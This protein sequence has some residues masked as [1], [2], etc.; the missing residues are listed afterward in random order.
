MDPTTFSLTKSAGVREAKVGDLVRYTLTLTNTGKANA[1]NAQVLDTPPAGFSYVAGSMAVADADGAFTLGASQSPLQIGGI[2][3]AAG[4]QATISYLLR[5]GA[6]VRQGLYT[7]QAVAQDASGKP[8]SNI[9]TAQVAVVGDP[10]VD[11]SLILGTVFHD[12]DGDGWQA[13]ATMSGVRVQGGF[14]PGVYQPGSTTVDRGQGPVPEPDASAPLLHGIEVGTVAGRQTVADAASNHQVVIR[15]RVSEPTFTDDFVLTSK[16]GVTLRMNAS[17]QTVVEKAGEAAKGMNGAAP[18]VER[19]I[20]QVDGAYEVAYIIRNEGIDERGIPGVRLATVEGLLIET[21]Q[22]GRFNVTG[23]PGG[24]DHRGRNFIMKVDP[25]TLPSGAEL[26]TANPLVRRITPG[27]PA[28]FD[29][30]V[31]APALVLEG[32]KEQVDVVLGEVLFAPGSTELDP[33]YEPVIQKMAAKVNE[34]AGGDVVI[35]AN[36]EAQALALGRAEA[37]ERAMQ[38]LLT[39]AAAKAVRVTARTEL[40]QPLSTVVG[41]QQG[42]IILGT[43]LFD[44]DLA[45]VK[46]QFRPL[47]VQVVKSLNERGG[48]VV[49]LVGHTDRRASDAYNLALGLRR[50]RAVFEAIAKELNPKVRAKVRVETLNDAQPAVRA[51]AKK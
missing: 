36:G 42:E 14:A 44:T 50:A 49:A 31:K 11:E 45:V 4:K 26:T 32:A 41:V 51:S 28:R 48:G 5:V 16:Q 13:P 24:N 47:L 1:A 34:Y 27:V 29:F 39:P 10:L 19:R 23:V 21:D 2:D 20:A 6:G 9:A 30:G 43:V 22:Y 37:V 18:T 7:N 25:S 38:K 15:Q 40:T 12:R 8:V 46:P 33:K 17:G 3:L 35:N